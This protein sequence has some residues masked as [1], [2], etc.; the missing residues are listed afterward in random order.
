[1][2]TIHCYAH[3]HF[4]ITWIYLCH[5]NVTIDGLLAQWADGQLV[6]FFRL[7]FRNINFTGLFTLFF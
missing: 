4:I 2:S 3:Q 5:G 6:N 1:M 7:Q